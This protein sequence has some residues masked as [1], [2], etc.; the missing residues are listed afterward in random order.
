M[1]GMNTFE[2]IKKKA[3]SDPELFVLKPQR[4]GGGN[5]LYGTDVLAALQRGG[6]ILKGYILMDRI[7][8][9]SQKASLV[10]EGSAIEVFFSLLFDVIRSCSIIDKFL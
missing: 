5:N 3:M 4:E 2:L 6:E 8:P 1:D 7:F 10:R 9:P